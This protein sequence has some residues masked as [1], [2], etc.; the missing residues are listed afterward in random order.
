MVLDVSVGDKNVGNVCPPYANFSE[1]LRIWGKNSC[2]PR[3][4]TTSLFMK[5]LVPC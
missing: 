2:H 5:M 1:T 3:K 4:I